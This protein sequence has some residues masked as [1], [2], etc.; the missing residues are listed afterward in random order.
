MILKPQMQLPDWSDLNKCGRILNKA[1]V[2]GSL[3]NSVA[4]TE[5]RLGNN[6]A[7]WNPATKFPSRL[8][9]SVATPD[10]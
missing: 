4:A 9:N 5:F 6:V 10:T 1:I 2:T 8:G 3:G 7:Y